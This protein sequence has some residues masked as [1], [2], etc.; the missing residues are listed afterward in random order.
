MILGSNS[1]RRQELLKLICSDFK[2]ATIE[3]DETIEKYKNPVDLVKQIAKKKIQAYQTRF[4]NDDIIICADT[5][6]EKDGKI[7]G[8]PHN[9]QEAIE[10]IN[11]LKHTVHNVYTCVSISYYGKIKTFLERTKVYVDDIEESQIIEYVKT[12]EPY[13][14]AGGYGIQGTFA[15]YISRIDGDYYNVMGLPVSRLYKELNNL[16]KRNCLANSRANC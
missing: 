11:T 8:K 10:M 3:V 12:A 13:D 9:E 14:K 2:V 15:K 16:R 5:I 7:L 1:P 6:V 4:G